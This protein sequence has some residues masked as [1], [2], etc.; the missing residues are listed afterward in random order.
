[1]HFIAEQKKFMEKKIINVEV[2]YVSMSTL[3][4]VIIP[5]ALPPKSTILQAINHSGILS[6]FP[7]IEVK[8]LEG[9]VG[10]YGQIK[11]L[12][13]LLKENDRVEIYSNLQQDPKE[14]RKKRVE[15]AK[16]LA[17]KE[18]NSRALAK[19]NARK[20]AAFRNP[21]PNSG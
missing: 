8:T 11:A 19:K 6:L 15:T 14:A 9:R 7:E 3:E 5:L 17:A 12:N 2:A 10:I 4:Q 18:A 21:N 16:A 20:K 1:M 13:T